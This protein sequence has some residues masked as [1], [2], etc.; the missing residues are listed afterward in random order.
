MILESLDDTPH[1]IGC[2]KAHTFPAML[3]DVRTRRVPIASGRNLAAAVLLSALTAGCG[4]SS[5]QLRGY[6]VDTFNTRL[7][8]RAQITRVVEAARDSHANAL[9]AQVRRRG[10]AWYVDSLEPP[11]DF[12][13]FE[14][15]LDPLR[16][17]IAQAHAQDP[18]IE[19]HAFVITG[20]L[21]NKNPT[22][23]SGPDTGRPLDPQHV[24]NRHGGYDP[25]TRTIVSGPL[26]WL[27]RTRD[28]TAPGITFNGYRFGNEFWM[29]P[30]HPDAAA[31]TAD[32]LGHLV[33]RY[34][35][36]GLHLDRIRYPEYSGAGQSPLGG[37]SVGYND[38]SVERFQRHFGIP[39]GSPPPAPGEARWAQWRRDQ[40]SALVR[41][42]YLTAVARRPQIAVSAALIAFGGGPERE[43]EWPTRAEAYWRVY[44]D[45][46]AWTEEGILDIAI[47]M[48]YKRE[49][50]PVQQT[51]YDVWLEW[52]KSH[53]YS[54][55]VAIGQGA[56]LNGIEGT[57][58]QTRRALA[59]A[60]PGQATAGVVFFSLANSNVAVSAN[61]FAQ[62]LVADT[63]RRP[64]GDFS[65]AL[66]TGR[67]A[68]WREAFEASDLAPVFG[69]RVR[70][71]SLSWK[72]LPVLGHLSGF[73]RLGGAPAD[74]VAV[75]VEK[76]GTRT[77]AGR[78]RVETRTDGSGFY[79]ALDL[80]PGEYQVS[81]TAPGQS[82]SGVVRVEP[83]RVA[84]LDL[85]P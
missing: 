15:G 57:L 71:P 73:V 84:R 74:T 51:D 24:F 32:V 25:V 79:G 75:V 72:V 10:D 36:D 30:G 14:A 21:W 78:H 13:P 67:S 63:V 28:T 48:V 9:F 69:A 68:D 8:T 3:K 55:A 38:T 23:A 46:R 12:L 64:E 60:P 62:P 37:A 7:E 81:V 66:V 6:W 85:A 50:V 80:E 16:E 83:G 44:Q 53:S 18:P 41:R 22:L 42:I 20:A 5:P 70:A 29:D 56:F 19:V 47:P 54:R 27:T 1:L 49:H 17:L 2:A 39:I 31:Y 82:R 43:E 76:V 35:L 4:D 59:P 40:V 77:G 45:W 52:T 58:R 33:E 11:P 26:N 65:A 34:A 61:P